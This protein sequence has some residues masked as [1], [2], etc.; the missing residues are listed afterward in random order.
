MGKSKSRTKVSKKG[1]AVST[2]PIERLSF[3][4]TVK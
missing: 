1:I 3:D 2:E 4:L